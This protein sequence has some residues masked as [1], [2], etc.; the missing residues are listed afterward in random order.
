[1]QNIREEID[2]HGTPKPKIGDHIYVDSSLSISHGSDD[3]CGGLATISN[4]KKSMSAGDMVW[5]IEISESNSRSYNYKM[6]I[7][8]GKQ[9]NLKKEF[10]E[11]KAHPDPDIDTPWIEEGDW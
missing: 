5:F 10:G 2:D 7:E 6:L 9:E 1:M 4:V 3:F 11:N 8:T